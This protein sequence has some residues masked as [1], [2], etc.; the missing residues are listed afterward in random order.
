LQRLTPTGLLDSA[1][2]ERREIDEG[3]AKLE[4]STESM[5][6]DRDLEPSTAHNPK[7]STPKFLWLLNLAKILPNIDIIN[8]G[9]G[10]G[11]K[12]K[13]HAQPGQQKLHILD[14]I[15]PTGKRP[16]DE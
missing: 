7:R 6:V 16:G 11:T 12:R 2:K 15:G 9:G 5:R 14:D 10:E 8:S 3:A 4:R 13:G 1:G